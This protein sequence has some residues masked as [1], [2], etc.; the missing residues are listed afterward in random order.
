M[1][2]TFGS[3]QMQKWILQI[4]RAE[5]VVEKMGSFVYFP[6]SVCLVSIFCNFVL[7][8]A[9]NLNLLKQFTYIHV[10]VLVTHFQ[11]MVLFVMLWLPV[12]EILER[13]CLKSKD[14]VA[15]K[16]SIFLIFQLLINISWTMAQTPVNH[17]IFWKSVMRNFRCIYVNFFNRLRFL[18]EFST[19]LQTM[20]FSGQFKDHKSGRKHGSQTNNPIFHLLFPI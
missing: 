7:A 12:S 17:M 2:T 11:K 19:K 10:K 6:C 20:H 9:R 5:K 15:F 13:F 8:S 16:L 1:K 4:V 14:F 3:L 18:V